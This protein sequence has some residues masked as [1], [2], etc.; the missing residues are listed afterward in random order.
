VTPADLRQASL[1]LTMT[2]RQ[3]ERVAA[4]YPPGAA[5]ARIFTL[6][7]FA[8]EQ[9]DIADPYLGDLAAY[10]QCARQLDRLVGKALARFLALPD[11]FP[12]GRE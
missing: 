2:G 7:A 9:G 11:F 5:G 10:R 8:G 4:G 1:V 12:P 3:A 6:A